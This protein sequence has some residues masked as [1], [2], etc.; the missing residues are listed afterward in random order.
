MRVLL[1]IP[2]RTKY[3]SPFEPLN[4]SL[5]HYSANLPFKSQNLWSCCGYKSAARFGFKTGP[6]INWIKGLQGPIS[7]NLVH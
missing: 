1:V 7:Q 3:L 6:L 5:A 4:I 2:K